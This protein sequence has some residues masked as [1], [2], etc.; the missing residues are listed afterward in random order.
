MCSRSLAIGSAKTNA[1]TTPQPP[2]A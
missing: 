1:G 2:T